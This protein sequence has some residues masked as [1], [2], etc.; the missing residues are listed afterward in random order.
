VSHGPVT[1]PLPLGAQVIVVTP[2]GEVRPTWETQPTAMPTPSQK[3][4]ETGQTHQG[5]RCL[6]GGLTGAVRTLEVISWYCHNKR[7]FPVVN[8]SWLDLL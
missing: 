3:A 2:H 1:D 5:V 6:V 7:D 4:M 8:P